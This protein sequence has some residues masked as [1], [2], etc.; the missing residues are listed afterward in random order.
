[1]WYAQAIAPI[2]NLSPSLLEPIKNITLDSRCVQKEA[3]TLQLRE[4]KSMDIC[5]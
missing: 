2:L 5:L 4:R 3:F 1:M